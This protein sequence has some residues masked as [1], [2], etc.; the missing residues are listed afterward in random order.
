MTEGVP[1]KPDKPNDPPVPGGED[2]PKVT[3]SDVCLD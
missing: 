1:G 3:V 2:E